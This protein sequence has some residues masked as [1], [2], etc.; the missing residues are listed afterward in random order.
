MVNSDNE[1]GDTEQVDLLELCTKE[2]TPSTALYMLGWNSSEDSS[3]VSA[4]SSIP[5][6][7]PS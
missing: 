6:L 1:D 7:T 2:G 3:R 5:D 4:A